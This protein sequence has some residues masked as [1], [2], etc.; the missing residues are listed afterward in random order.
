MLLVGWQEGHLACNKT[1]WWGVGVV[2]ICLGRGADLLMAQLI[3][4]PLT[5]SC[6]R[7]SSLVFVLPFWY[8]LT[9]LVPDKI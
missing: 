9:W 8:Q 3:P 4:L 2:I 5:V 6:F 1:E 7:K